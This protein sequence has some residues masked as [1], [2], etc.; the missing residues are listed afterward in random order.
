MDAIVTSPPYEGGGHHEGTFDTWGGVQRIAAR[1]ADKYTP[2][3]EPGSNIGNLRNAAYW[4]EI[5]KVYA[6]CWRVLRPGG[7]L[8]LVLKGFTRDGKYVDLPGQTEALLLAAGWAK[9]DHWKRE[10]YSLSFW[11]ILQRRKDPAAFDNRLWFEEVL[12]FKKCME[13]GG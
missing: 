3:G 8:A 10:L 4:S 7:I 2:I 5:S 12:V 9:H 13:R 6:E 1:L 11:R